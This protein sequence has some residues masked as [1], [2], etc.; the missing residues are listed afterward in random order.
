MK[1][2]G[3]E[4]KG[5][6]TV[7]IIIQDMN[8]PAQCWQCPFHFRLDTAHTACSRKPME[9]P[10]EDGDERPKYC[11]LEELDCRDCEQW[12]TCPCGKEGH[13]K[14]AAIGYSPG[15]CREFKRRTNNADD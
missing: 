7:A 1:M 6:Y 9:D 14:G 12:E 15:E 10:V 2:P 13:D 5:G 3:I 11:P 4:N 8:M